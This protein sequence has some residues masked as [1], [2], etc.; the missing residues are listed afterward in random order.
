MA[1]AETEHTIMQPCHLNYVY[2]MQMNEKS[3][4]EN[5]QRPCLHTH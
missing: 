2:D 1:T 3:D 5:M 4:R